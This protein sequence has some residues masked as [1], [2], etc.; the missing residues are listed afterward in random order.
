MTQD[1]HVVS[2][3]EDYRGSAVSAA[4]TAVGEDGLRGTE[5]VGREGTDQPELGLLRGR[6]S[7]HNWSFRVREEGLLYAR[8]GYDRG[9]IEKTQDSEGGINWK[10]GRRGMGEGGSR[11]PGRRA[12]T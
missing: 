7:R 1:R 4:P 8:R 2:S 9:G 5:A 3:C 12:P 11:G 6:T 10:G